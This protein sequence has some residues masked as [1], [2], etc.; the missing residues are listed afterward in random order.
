MSATKGED[1]RP[2]FKEM[3]SEIL[4]DGVRTIIVESLERLAGLTAFR[5]AF[6][7]PCRKQH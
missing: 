7:L 4:R 2:A 6:D 1:D 3:V 5:T